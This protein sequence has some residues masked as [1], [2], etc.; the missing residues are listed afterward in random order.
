M[1]IPVW[2]TESRYT[3]RDEMNRILASISLFLLSLT[4]ICTSVYSQASPK[5]LEVSDDDGLPVLVK[6]LP[7]WQN[8]LADP[9]Y[10]HF[11]RS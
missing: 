4:A 6:H 7:D 8:V 1:K 9:F 10:K 3:G 2:H 5:G 11:G